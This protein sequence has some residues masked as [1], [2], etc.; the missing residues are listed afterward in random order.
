MDGVM[1]LDIDA[2]GAAL[3]YAISMRRTTDVGVG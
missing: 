3:L 1:N 2:E